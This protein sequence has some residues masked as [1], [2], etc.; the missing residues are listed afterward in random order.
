ME[1]DGDYRSVSCFSQLS[2]DA[3]TVLPLSARDWLRKRSRSTIRRLQFILG[4]QGNI[5]FH[6]IPPDKA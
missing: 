6:E 1:A 5:D 4:K 3:D 2:I